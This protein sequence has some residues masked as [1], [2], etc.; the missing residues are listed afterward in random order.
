MLPAGNFRALRALHDEALKGGLPM[1]PVKSVACV[2]FFV[3]LR[4]M[5]NLQYLGLWLT[6]LVFLDEMNVTSGGKV[7]LAYLKGVARV[8]ENVLL[9]QKTRYEL[10]PSDSISD[11]IVH[12]SLC[13]DEAALFDMSLRCEPK[14]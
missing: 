14:V 8:L 5:K 11:Y 6:D 3:L 2:C 9:A 1:V 10:I 4:N 7:S 12:S 13:I